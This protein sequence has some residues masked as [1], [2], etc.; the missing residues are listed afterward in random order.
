MWIGT[1]CWYHLTHLVEYSGL[2]VWEM[3]LKRLGCNFKWHACVYRMKRLK[4]NQRSHSP[5]TKSSEPRMAGMS[6][7]MW[8][9]RRREVMDR[10]QNE[11]LR[12]L[13]R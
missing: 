12:I 4:M 8:P 3:G 11:G 13:R 2:N 9:G 1:D 6:D 10:L 5:M 7:T